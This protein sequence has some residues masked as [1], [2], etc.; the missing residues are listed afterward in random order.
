MIAQ[1]VH[2]LV[3]YS[4]FLEYR[5]RR[6]RIAAELTLRDRTPPDAD[7]KPAPTEIASAHSLTGAE[8][9]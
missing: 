2:V 4:R 5:D 1:L 6:D 7:V 8:I 9:S 3:P